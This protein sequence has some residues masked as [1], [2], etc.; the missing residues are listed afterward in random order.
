MIHTAFMLLCKHEIC[1][2]DD[3]FTLFNKMLFVI[4]FTEQEK[5]KKT[6]KTFNLKRAYR[7]TQEQWLQ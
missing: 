6:M 7:G 2:F 4:R 5:S 1:L 3:R